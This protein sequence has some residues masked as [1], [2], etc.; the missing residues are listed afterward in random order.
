[1]FCFEFLLSQSR[2]AKNTTLFW[3]MITHA[4]LLGCKILFFCHQSSVQYQS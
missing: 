2:K 1:L 3:I 4:V